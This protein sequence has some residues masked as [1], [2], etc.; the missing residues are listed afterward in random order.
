[1]HVRLV[2]WQTCCQ[3]PVAEEEK[4]GTC[5]APT[6]RS[7]KP[8]IWMS[9]FLAFDIYICNEKDDSESQG[10]LVVV[11]LKKHDGCPACYLP[12]KNA[13]NVMYTLKDA[14]SRYKVSDQ[15]LLR[16]VAWINPLLSW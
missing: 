16:A 15:G 4:R 11:L 3:L 10:T 1:M 13:C 7:L 2:G 12:K 5:Q 14:R 8:I 6:I 9:A